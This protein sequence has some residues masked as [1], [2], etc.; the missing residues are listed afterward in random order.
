MMYRQTHVLDD[1][2]AR[3]GSVCL[4]EAAARLGAAGGGRDACDRH[5]R[6]LVHLGAVVLQRLP[7]PRLLT[8]FNVGG[9]RS[10]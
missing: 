7:A 10:W 4:E 3:A 9:G 2:L 5:R 8:N 1:N 6:A